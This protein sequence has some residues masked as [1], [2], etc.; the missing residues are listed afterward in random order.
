MSILYMP[1]QTFISGFSALITDT[2]TLA[3]DGR[4]SIRLPR[5]HRLASSGNQTDAPSGHKLA[6][7]NLQATYKST[8]MVEL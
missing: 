2:L 8:K 6:F 7:C 1:V 5:P 3:A 4:T